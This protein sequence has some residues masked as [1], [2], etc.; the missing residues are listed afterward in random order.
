MVNKKPVVIISGG[1]RG[2]GSTLVNRCLKRGYRV[3]TFSRNSSDYIENQLNNDPQNDKFLWQA[4][5]LTKTSILQSF[6]KLT[7]NKYGRIDALVNNVG[8][9]TN[10]ILAL[11]SLVDIHNCIDFNITGPILLTQL[12]SKVMIRQKSGCIVNISSVNAIRG[13]TGV[14]VYS[15]TKAALDGLTRSLARELGPLNIRINSVAPGY[16]ESDMVQELSEEQKNRIKRRTPLGRLAKIN[17]IANGVM[18][19]LSPG[20]SFITG[21]TLIVDGGITC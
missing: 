18:F 6:I 21:Q 1:S 14:G 16:F 13:H 8:T 5:D 15:A 9:G 3:A 17:E 12:C 11:T 7:L 19:M 10:G 2:L 20:A 4:V